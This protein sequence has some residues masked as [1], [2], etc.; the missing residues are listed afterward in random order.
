MMNAVLL[1]GWVA[2]IFGSLKLSLAVLEK[3]GLLADQE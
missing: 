1:I 2:V 3:A